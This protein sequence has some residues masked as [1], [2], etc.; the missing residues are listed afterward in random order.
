M[1]FL[2]QVK[3]QI[4]RTTRALRADTQ[5]HRGRATVSAVHRRTMRNAPWTENRLFARIIGDSQR[6]LVLAESTIRHDV[7]A[8][9]RSMT[10]RMTD[11]LFF[12]CPTS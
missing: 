11:E 5:Q 2:V 3:H 4:T 10:T 7:P 8:A 9:F 12:L 6:W 1:A